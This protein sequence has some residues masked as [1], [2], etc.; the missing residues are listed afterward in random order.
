MAMDIRR[1]TACAQAATALLEFI[2]LI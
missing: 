2:R 1:F